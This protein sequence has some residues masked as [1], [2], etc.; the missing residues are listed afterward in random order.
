MNKSNLGEKGLMW[1][2]LP[3]HS[4]PW[5][6]VRAGTQGINLEARTKAEAIE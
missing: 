1:L 2:T 5:K 6:E 3:H 4:L